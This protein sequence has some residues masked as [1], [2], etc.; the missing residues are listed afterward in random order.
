LRGCADAGTSLPT[1]RSLGKSERRQ[2]HFSVKHP[3]RVPCRWKVAEPRKCYPIGVVAK[4]LKA[5]A[6]GADPAEVS[7]SLRMALMLEGV[8]CRPRR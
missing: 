5:A 6:D 7:I 1:V 4:D 3:D 2:L 8:E